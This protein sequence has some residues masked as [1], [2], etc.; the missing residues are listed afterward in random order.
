VFTAG[1]AVQGLRDELKMIETAAESE[2][3]ANSERDTNGVYFVP[4]FTGLGT[5]YWDAY[6][7][8][9]VVGLTRGTNKGHFIRAA[10]ESLAYQ[11]S[12]LLEAM[13]SSSGI[14]PKA[15]QVDGGACANDFLMQFQADMIGV[16]VMRPASIET[17]A[18][19]AAYL[20]GLAAGYWTKEEILSDHAGITA[21]APQIGADRRSE[22]LGAWHR[23]VKRSLRWV[24][25]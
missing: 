12:D 22:L 24:V 11:S 5:P 2:Y 18:K 8:G 7:R 17:T 20:A 4:A 3:W 16:P 23:A 9:T 14:A 25:K 21:F 13:R 19:G 6:A 10:L 15:L 1:A